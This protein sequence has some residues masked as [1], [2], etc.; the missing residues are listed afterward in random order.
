MVEYTTTQLSIR[1]CV[2]GIEILT[3]LMMGG[4]LSEWLVVFKVALN[5][6]VKRID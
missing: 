4:F 2:V 1:L 6:L 3:L 5:G